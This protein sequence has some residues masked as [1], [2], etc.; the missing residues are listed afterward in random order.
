MIVFINNLRDD[1][2]TANSPKHDVNFISQRKMYALTQLVEHWM[3][4]RDGEITSEVI[5]NNIFIP[6]NVCTINIFI[7]SV[8]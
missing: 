7:I 3:Q 1:H 6:Y 2:I 5:K 8:N 4:R